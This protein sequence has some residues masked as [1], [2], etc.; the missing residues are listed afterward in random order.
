MENRYNGWANWETWLCSLWID[1]SDNHSWYREYAIE[2]KVST[3]DI[4]QMLENEIWDSYKES[5]VSGFFSDIIAN[6]IREVDFVE[7]A[8]SILEGVDV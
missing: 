1:Q 2:H 3:E 6:A 4:A 8:E 7:I 5:K